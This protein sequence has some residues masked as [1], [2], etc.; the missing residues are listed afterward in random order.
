MVL[1]GS[2]FSGRFER[3]VLSKGFRLAKGN[4]GVF[5]RGR[6]ASLEGS[7]DLVGLVLVSCWFSWVYSWTGS[8]CFSFVCLLALPLT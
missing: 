3:S 5:G 1:K 7:L 8:A 2:G 6:G 4:S